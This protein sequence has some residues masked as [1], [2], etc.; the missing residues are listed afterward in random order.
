MGG[1][2]WV[3]LT[4]RESCLTVALVAELTAGVGAASIFGSHPADCYGHPLC[5]SSHLSRSE[6]PPCH[7]CTHIY[8][9]TFPSGA[10]SLSHPFTEEPQG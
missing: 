1:G 2:I 4:A 8:K 6:L 9:L 7:A 3:L 5:F 10:S